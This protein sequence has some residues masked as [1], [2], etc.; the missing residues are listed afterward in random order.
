M[1]VLQLEHIVRTIARSTSGNFFG[2]DA[3]LVEQT[4]IFR[5]RYGT[6]AGSMVLAVYELQNFTSTIRCTSMIMIVYL[7]ICSWS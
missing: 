7:I 2:P 5:T 1:A 3:H 6:A 4:P